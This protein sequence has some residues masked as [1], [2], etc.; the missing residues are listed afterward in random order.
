MD[1]D[2]EV[3]A[4]VRADAKAVALALSLKTDGETSRC[5]CLRTSDDD[6]LPPRG[7]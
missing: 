1:S 7:G 5:S 2:G 6:A 4:V 3:V